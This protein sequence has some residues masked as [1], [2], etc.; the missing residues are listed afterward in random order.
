MMF[1]V[2]SS[3]LFLLSGLILLGCR[4]EPAAPPAPAVPVK[5]VPILATRPRATSA[6][7]N[8]DAFPLTANP[9]ETVPFLASDALAGRLP[10]SPGLQRAGD[11]LALECARIGLQPL[12][13]QHDF[14]QPLSMNESATLS[15]AT[16]LSVNGQEL[17]LARDFDPMSLSAEK[18]FE[19]KVVFAGFG[20][21]RDAGDPSH[22][23]DYTGI[24][25]RGKVVLAMMKEPL[26]DKGVSRFAAGMSRWS[27]SALFT[28][29]AKNAADHG[30]TALLLVAPPSSGGA[31]IVNLYTGDG[32]TASAIPVVQ[33]TRR[34][35]NLLLSMGGAA[36]LKSL[37]DSIYSSFKP[38]SS[39]LNDLEIT[40]DVEVSRTQVQVRNVLACLPG[41]GPNADQWVVVGAHYDHLGRGQMGHMMGGKA[42]SIW[43]GADD[44]AS[45]TSAVLELA[46]K[47]QQGPPLPRSVLF[48]FF[49][50]EEEGLI[51][52]D[53]FV[54]HPLI[55]LDHV[56]AML[57][58][59]MVGRLRGNA[60][61]I[62]GAGTA[63]NFDSI[64]QSAVAG[65]KLTTSTALPD[66]GGRGGMGPSDHMSFA[67]HKIPVL[68]LFTGMHADYHRPTDTAD[69]INYDG[70]DIVTAVGQRIVAAMAAMPRQKYDDRNDSGMMGAMVPGGHSRRAVLGVVPDDSA[71]ETTSGVPISGVSSG[72]AADLAGLKPGDVIVGFNSKPMKTLGDLSEALDDAHGGDTVVV[73]VLREGK[74]VDLHAVLQERN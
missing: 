68:F 26:D 11:F 14:F 15:A 56:V 12:P 30:A 62:G 49:T 42:G 9:R 52:S 8:P 22:Y 4:T 18:P 28:V 6:S 69:K 45:G 74:S 59:D 40:G 35:A 36:D 25:A 71:G 21:T 1:A 3:L 44:N 58:L 65:T 29:K 23:D 32:R 72:S 57:N 34:V 73:K 60:L 50:G 47:L 54:N 63:A 20:I 51:G 70:I 39:L 7:A 38:N 33:I 64:V 17:V 16:H 27:N 53:Y 46:E 2:R 5:A 67:R 41:R 31:D 13:G 37:Q 61:E 55:P 43:H 24:D 66:D 48:I 10:G 19:G